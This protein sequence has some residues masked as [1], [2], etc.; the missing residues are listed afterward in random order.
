MI[1]PSPTAPE[2]SV[3]HL[4]RYSP[5]D[6]PSTSAIL[7]RNTAPLVSLAFS[8]IR[9]GIGCRVLGREIGQGLVTLIKKLNAQD[10]FQLQIKLEMYEAREVEKFER[11]GEL[12]S[13]DSIRDKCQCISIFLSASSSIED[14]CNRIG[15]LFDDNSKGLLTLST[16]HKSKGLEWPKVFILDKSKLMPSPFARLDWQK[17][18]EINLIYVAI[19]R[20]KLD[21]VY[22]ESDKWKEE[23]EKEPNLSKADL[24][25]LDY[26]TKLENDYDR[27]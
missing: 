20:A 17:Q 10:I 19:T 24:K 11:K 4:D 25:D 14:L 21:L 23:K 5:S 27:D 8:L 7:C 9:R 15:N 18:Q 6:F 1:L 22:I 12:Q 16:V 13:A 26:L 2:G 3:T